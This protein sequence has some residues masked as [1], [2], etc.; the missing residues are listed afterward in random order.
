MTSLDDLT[1]IQW[2]VSG[3]ATLES[4]QSLRIQPANR[5]RQLLGR[6]GTLLA[7]AD[8]AAVP[9]RVEVRRH[10]DYTDLLHEV[11]VDHHFVP[12]GQDLSSP[13]LCYVHYPIPPGYQLIYDQAR[14]LWKQWWIRFSRINHR[15][16]QLDLFVLIADQWYPVRDIA[17]NSGTL[18]IETLRGERIHHGDDMMVWIEKAPVEESEATCLWAPPAAPSEPVPP[19]VIA[20]PLAA[21]AATVDPT[22]APAVY[23]LDGKIY[24]QS[25]LGLVV[26]EGENL[27]AHRPTPP[28]ATVGARQRLS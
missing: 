4:N 15:H 2:F 16:L 3:D 20:P 1:I 14:Q 27:N 12:I 26:I 9:P 13:V 28:P 21:P 24:V 6:K 25:T 7:T 19:V 17:I 23:A 5:L 10:T 8:D 11:L 22:L 18:Y